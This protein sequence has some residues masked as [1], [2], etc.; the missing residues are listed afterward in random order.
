MARGVVVAWDARRGFGFVQ[1]TEFAED[2]FVH[3]S[4]V[5]GRVPLRTGQRVEFAAEP[6]DRGLRAVRVVPGRVGLSPT[7]A[8]GGLLLA[9]L[10]AVA[11]GLRELGA[12]WVVAVL[13][14]IWIVTW[15][16][17]AWDKRRAGLHERRVPELVLLG[18]ALLGGSPA[19]LAA[20]LVLRHKTRKPSFLL[21]FGL[22]AAVQVGLA[23]LYFRGR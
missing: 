23:V 2:V 14:A 4:S 11:G 17:Y 7:M 8:A 21:K 16:V 5:E 22:V 10:L 1:S 9:V 6:G 19:A 12:R 18:L 3:V 13:G 15:G 20:M